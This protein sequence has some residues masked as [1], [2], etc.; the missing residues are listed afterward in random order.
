MGA[1]RRGV[2][3]SATADVPGTTRSQAVSYAKAEEAQSQL[4]CFHATC[5]RVE[6]VAEDCGVVVATKQTH[7]WGTVE[8]VVIVNSSGS[9]RGSG[10]KGAPWTAGR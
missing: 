4:A 1:D 5:S 6:L 2:S 10:G 9:S 3:L 8:N 7:Y